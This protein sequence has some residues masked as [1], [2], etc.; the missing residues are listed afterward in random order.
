M[1][2]FHCTLHNTAFFKK[3]KMKRFAHPIG[4]TGEWCNMPEGQEPVKEAAS[5]ASPAPPAPITM[6]PELWAEKDRAK[7]D[8]IE[9]QVI[10][11]GI[12]G[13]FTAGKLDGNAPIV[14][15]I[16]GWGLEHFPND[17]PATKPTQKPA[18][19]TAQQAL[20]ASGDDLSGIVFGNAG[21]IKNYLK[22]IFEMPALNITAATAGF[23]LTTE[24]GRKDCWASILETR[25]EK[26]DE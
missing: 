15:A 17:K 14:K 3:G 18:S 16:I 25:G 21:E 10:F 2:E 9:K 11:T 23:D 7:Q 1:N 4:D 8:S 12:M 19:K 22:D 20:E 24:Q 5:P 26:G 13:A 6:T